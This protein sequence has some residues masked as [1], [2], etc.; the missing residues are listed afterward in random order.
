MLARAVNG[1]AAFWPTLGGGFILVGLHKTL[2]ML[3]RRSHRFGNLVKGRDVQ[4][5]Q[6]GVADEAA[7]R[8]HDVSNNDLIEDVSHAKCIRQ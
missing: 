8:K 4:I 7:M 6:D 3:S 1:T 2:A 5:V